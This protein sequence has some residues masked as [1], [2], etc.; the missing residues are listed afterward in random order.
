M[1]LA[2]VAGDFQQLD[3]HLEPDSSKLKL[4]FVD[5]NEESSII[6]DKQDILSQEEDDLCTFRGLDGE[7]KR[8]TVTTKCS[9][10]TSFEA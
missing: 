7:K 10:P 9:K 2:A 8:A 6:L 4:S 3:V 5:N 1:P